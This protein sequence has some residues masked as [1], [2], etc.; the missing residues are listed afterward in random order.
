MIPPSF[1]PGSTLP[2]KYPF[3]KVYPYRLLSMLTV[4]SWPGM[5]ANTSDAPQGELQESLDCKDKNLWLAVGR[6]LRR[7]RSSTLSFDRF[8]WQPEIECE[9]AVY[10]RKNCA[11]PFASR[12]KATGGFAHRPDNWGLVECTRGKLLPTHTVA[13]KKCIKCLRI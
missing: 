10:T 1:F 4:N 7:W 11:R 9:I 2:S 6:S 3:Q 8:P 5:A 13:V 12:K